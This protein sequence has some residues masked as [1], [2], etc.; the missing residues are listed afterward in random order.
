MGEGEGEVEDD[1]QDADLESRVADCIPH[2]SKGRERGR[3]WRKDDELHFECTGFEVLSGTHLE[4]AGVLER[5]RRDVTS[6]RDVPTIE[7]VVE[8]RNQ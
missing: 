5:G 7:A 2:N 1:T 8:A 3:F 4:D 6:L